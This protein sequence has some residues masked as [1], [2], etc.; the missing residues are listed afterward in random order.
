[1]E[2]FLSLL[3]DWA[4]TFGWAVVGSLAMAFSFFIF[5]KLF[6]SFTKELDEIKELKNNN[7]AVGVFMAGL[8]IAFAIIVSTAM[9]LL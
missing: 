6:D 1:M 9:K 5:I 8:L 2:R 3:L 7:L 4:V